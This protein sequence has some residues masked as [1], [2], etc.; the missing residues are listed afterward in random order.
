[1]PG[2][3]GQEAWDPAAGREQSWNAD[4]EGGS[5]A[6]GRACARARAKRGSLFAE[7]NRVKLRPRDSARHLIRQDER[8]E[9]QREAQ[10][11]GAGHSKRGLLPGVKATLRRKRAVGK[12]STAARAGATRR[13]AALA[14]G[15]GGAALPPAARKVACGGAGGDP[16]RALPPPGP[17]DSELARAVASGGP[18]ECARAASDVAVTR[19]GARLRRGSVS[20]PTTRSGRLSG[21]EGSSDT[22]QPAPSQAGSAAPRRRRPQG[23]DSCGEAPGDGAQ[24]APRRDSLHWV[25]K[26]MIAVGSPC[27]AGLGWFPADPDDPLG[28]T[29]SQP[30]DGRSSA[31]AAMGSSAH[32]TAWAPSRMKG[33]NF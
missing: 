20:F 21:G 11:W 6:A 27:A 17:P 25:E 18:N 19:G 15:C 1:V 8:D 28:V 31:P 5:P 32:D 16:T 10:L 23:G 29:S 14:D 3:D 4:S 12:A 2:H 9:A 7:L 33:V 22:D 13:A 26:V 24:R 30:S